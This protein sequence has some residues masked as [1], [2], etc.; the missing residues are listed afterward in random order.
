VEGRLITFSSTLAKGNLA[1]MVAIGSHS[2]R[3]RGVILMCDMINIA[4]PG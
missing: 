2:W 4:L 3:G 1:L